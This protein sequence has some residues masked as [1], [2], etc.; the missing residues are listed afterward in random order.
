[1]EQNGK[2]PGNRII[3]KMYPQVVEVRSQ[4]HIAKLVSMDVIL[5]IIA[6]DSKGRFYNIEIQ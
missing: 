5:E 6:R 1:M 2:N 3:R 4:E